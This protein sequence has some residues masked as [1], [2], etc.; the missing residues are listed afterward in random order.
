MRARDFIEK[1]LTSAGLTRHPTKGQFLEPSQV[2]VDHLGFELNIPLN[3]LRVP[4]RRCV[5][6]RRLATAL[7]CESARNRRLV[8]SSL[9]RQFAGVA[10]STQ[11][12]VRSAR[13]HLRAIYDCLAFNCPLS[14]LDRAALH[15]LR[16]W[17]IF[18]FTSE[19]NS[20]PV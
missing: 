17:S 5:K 3:L 16:F 14:R 19:A 18:K 10:C 7:L 20:I 13:F 1:T 4:E 9:L 6:I 8:D 2:L 11:H 12:A 15:D